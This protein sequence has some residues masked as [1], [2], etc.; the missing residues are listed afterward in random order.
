M[1]PKAGTDADSRQ[2]RE[3][4]FNTV[5]P[6]MLLHHKQ[7]LIMGG[8]C[9][10]ITDNNECTQ[11]PDQKKSPTLKRLNNL[12]NLKDTYKKLYPKGKEFSRYYTSKDCNSGATRLDRIYTSSNLTPTYAKY[13]PHP[14]SDHY[15]FIT[16]IY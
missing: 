9:N 15:S 6:N 13:L 16:K 7:N 3:E 5:I 1:Y 14:F 12:H 11:H 10:C 4:F 2:D 8:D